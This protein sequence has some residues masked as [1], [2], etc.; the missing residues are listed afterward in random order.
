MTADFLLSQIFDKMDISGTFDIANKYDKT[1]HTRAYAIFMSNAKNPM[2]MY[3]AA[4]RRMPSKIMYVVDS[5]V[6]PI[7]IISSSHHII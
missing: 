5:I 7:I 2:D 6:N 3:I 4:N 1:S